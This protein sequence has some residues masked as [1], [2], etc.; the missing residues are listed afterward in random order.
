MADAT[1]ATT[2]KALVADSQ[3]WLFNKQLLFKQTKNGLSDNIT[4][5][6]ITQMTTPKSWLIS[7]MCN[8]INYL[9]DETA[10]LISRNIVIDCVQDGHVIIASEAPHS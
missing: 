7:K 5:A 4:V 10:G 2:K 3:T 9:T 8:S 1:H 6:N